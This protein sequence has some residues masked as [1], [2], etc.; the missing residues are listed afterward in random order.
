M[1]AQNEVYM[2]KNDFEESIRKILRQM[3]E[4]DEINEDDDVFELGINASNSYEFV[5]ELVMETGIEL[6][7]D[8]LNQLPQI[9]MIS[10]YLLSTPYEKADLSN[11]YIL[12]NSNNPKNELRKIFFFPNVVALAM[13]YQPLAYALD[14]Y[15]I[16]SFN[17]I[18]SEDR[19]NKYISYIKSI[20]PEGPYLFLGNCVGGNMAFEVAKALI[21]K[22]DTVSDIIFIDSFYY[23]KTANK[24]KMSA[25]EILDLACTYV[26]KL[27]DLF[28]S[29]KNNGTSF[30]S[31]LEKKIA[32]FFTYLSEY[33]T[34]GQVN[35]TI[36]QLEAGIRDEG[37]SENSSDNMSQWRNATTSKYTTYQ[38][39]GTHE[40]MIGKE[41][42]K[43]N[44]D[45]IKEILSRSTK[46]S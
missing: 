35:A 19:I 4:I 13:L 34:T 16:Y 41:Y 29:L 8:D 14:E 43:D 15:D 38:G 24:D 36:H 31:T 7:I 26:E 17:F 2:M 20:Q 40:L 46:G 39:F 1:C 25:E 33:V 22:G 45:I 30:A 6:K 44:V 11:D 12:L 5:S 9:S 21:E 3:F 28:P 32:S 27:L 18:E 42:V 37:M 10:D 23:N